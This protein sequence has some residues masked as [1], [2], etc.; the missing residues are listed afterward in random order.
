MLWL[1]SNSTNL[2]TIR[3]FNLI[4]KGV[5]AEGSGGNIIVGWQ[6]R[7]VPGMVHI[8]NITMTN[9]VGRGITFGYSGARKGL[10]IH[11]TIKSVYIGQA[12]PYQGFSF[13]GNTFV[14]TT[15]VNHLGTT[16]L[17]CVE[18]SI[19]NGGNAGNGFFD[20]YDGAEFVVR[21]CLLI[22]NAPSGGHGA[23]SGFS[24]RSSEVYNNIFYQWG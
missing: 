10:V 16:N 23:D 11:C 20:A 7:S 12:E 19:D 1:F 21:H 8:Y 5:D 22:G 3:D 24:M 9:N 17:I 14:S 2:F 6:N 13:E 15:N 4:N 18:V